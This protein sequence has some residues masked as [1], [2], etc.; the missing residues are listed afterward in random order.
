[1]RPPVVAADNQSPLKTVGARNYLEKVRA[2]SVHGKT[3]EKNILMNMS[4]D[5]KCLPSSWNKRHQVSASAFNKKNKV[6]HKVS[7]GQVVTLL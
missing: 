2:G 4:S 6:Y 1:M 5:G 7:N 3:D